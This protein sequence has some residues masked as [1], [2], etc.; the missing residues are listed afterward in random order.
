MLPLCLAFA[1]PLAWPH[2]VLPQNDTFH[3]QF[4][5]VINPNYGL[6]V[7]ARATNG[8][9][10]HQWQTSDTPGSD[11]GVPM[12]GWHYLTIQNGTASDGNHPLVFWEDPVAALNLDGRAEIFIRLT[13]D[14]TL[15]HMYQTNAK[16][17]QA[18]DQPRGP[19]CLCN[20]PPCKNL[21]QTKCGLSASCDNKGVDCSKADPSSF[22]SDHTG[23]P[24][25]N[26][27]THVDQ[28]TGQISVFY[29]GF[30]GAMYR[31]VQAIPGNSTKYTSGKLWLYDGTFE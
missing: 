3:Q 12:S 29:R 9:L 28:K 8:S 30:T 11:G 31:D 17:P 27:N 24:T 14:L 4:A 16:D 26:M 19:V 6:H 10:V 25:S 18:W 13:G 7:F 15:W 20:F 1:A 21:N 2:P 23:F 22:W 5:Q